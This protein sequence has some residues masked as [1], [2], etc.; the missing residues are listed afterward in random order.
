M[1]E[2]YAWILL[3]FSDSHDLVLRFNDAPTKNYEKDVGTK[4]TIRLLNSQ[5]VTKPKFRFLESEIFR[6]VTLVAWDPS[7]YTSTLADW[8]DDPDFNLFPNYM[9]Y[10]RSDPRSRFF[11]LNPHSLWRLWEF[12]QGN[13][14][15]RLR[16]NPPSSG[17]IGEAFNVWSLLKL[18]NRIYISWTVTCLLHPN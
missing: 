6:N 13:S 1:L 18:W 16:K 11:L 10:R 15:S 4:T 17:F 9:E 8:L 7:N 2:W 12:L 5:V 3:H 14:P